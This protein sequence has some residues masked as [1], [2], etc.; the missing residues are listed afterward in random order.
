MVIWSL[1]RPLLAV[2]PSLKLQPNWR[3][4]FCAAVLFPD[5]LLHAVCPGLPPQD[6]SP[7]GYWPDSCNNATTYLGLCSGVC[8][9]TDGYAG[10]PTVQCLNGGWSSTVVGACRKD[11]AGRSS[12][13]DADCRITKNGGSFWAVMR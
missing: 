7:G 12:S 1:D 13:S 3:F 9:V 10:S 8:N 5:V 4:F 11:V 2:D 6:L